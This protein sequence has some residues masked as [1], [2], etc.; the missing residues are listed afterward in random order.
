MSIQVNRITNANVYMDGESYLGR[1]EEVKLPEVSAMMTD[2]K[3]LGL[4]GKFELPSGIDK[5][6]GSIKWNSLYQDAFTKIANP[7][8]AVSLQVRANLDVY[9]AQG[10]VEQKALVVFMTVMFKK[11][12]GGMFKPHDN[13]EFDTSF[14]CQYMKTVIDGDEL[15]EVDVL[16]NIYKVAGVD[17]LAAYRDNLGA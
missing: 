15:L 17:Q 4:I 2:H 14:T 16:S 3:G 1:A 6:E 13:A 8:V 5:M 10:R 12:P 9:N 11:F 7:F